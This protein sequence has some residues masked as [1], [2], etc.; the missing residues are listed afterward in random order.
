MKRDSKEHRMESR[1]K[2]DGKSKAT[3]EDEGGSVVMV[4]GDVGGSGCHGIDIALLYRG[5]GSP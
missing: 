3:D 2:V 4:C 1:W 5:P